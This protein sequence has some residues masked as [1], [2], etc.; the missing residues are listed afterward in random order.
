ML[1]EQKW[2]NAAP[3]QFTLHILFYVVT[4]YFCALKAVLQAIKTKWL[5]DFN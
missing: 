4:R 5:S 2:C 1:T 3:G